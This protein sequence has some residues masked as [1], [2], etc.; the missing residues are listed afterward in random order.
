MLAARRVGRL[1]SLA[2]ELPDALAVPADVR[3]PAQVQA[4][5]D[6]AVRHYDGVDVLINNAGQGL[7]VPIEQ[8]KLEDLRAVMELNVFGALAGMQAVL[9]VMRKRGEGAIVNVSSGTSR[10]VLPGVGGY[11]ATKSALNMLSQV[12]RAEFAADNIAVSLVYPS[13]TATEFH[14]VL[15][16]G[17]YAGGG[18]FAPHSAEQVAEAILR[19]VQTGEP[20]VVL[21]HTPRA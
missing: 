19:A 10:T 12:A 4:V 1:E 15:R 16:A 2:A 11:A 5:I 9:P 14:T 21:A 13:V 17:A 20:E 6:A 8:I 7:H 18:R 3:D